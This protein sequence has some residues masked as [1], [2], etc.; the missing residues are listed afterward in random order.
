RRCRAPLPLAALG[1]AGLAA[2]GAHA[3]RAP[4][5][6]ALLEAAAETSGCAA[7]VAGAEGRQSGWQRGEECKCPKGTYLTGHDLQCTSMLD[8]SDIDRRYYFTA[9]EYEGRGCS[10][11]RLPRTEQQLLAALGEQ[12]RVSA[13]YE[14]LFRH[15]LEYLGALEGDG[16]S[17]FGADVDRDS[18]KPVAAGAFP[19]TEASQ[20]AYDPDGFCPLKSHSER[21][22][23]AEKVGGTI[24]KA[25]QLFNE[26]NVW[27][28][29]DGE[30]RP[31]NPATDDNLFRNGP[32]WLPFTPTW[33][34]V[35]AAGLMF[36]L[37]PTL[38]LTDGG[39]RTTW[40]NS[41]AWKTC[42]E[43]SPLAS[44]P[45]IFKYPQVQSRLHDPEQKRGYYTATAPQ[46]PD[47]FHPEGPLFIDGE[48]HQSFRRLLEL[49]G[50][51]RRYPVDASLVRAIPGLG[52]QAPSEADVA[53]AVGPLVMQGIWGSRPT[54][55]A[56]E[57][58]AIYA[59]FGKYA[60]FGKEIHRFALGPT[61]IASSV[62][63]ASASVAAWAKTTPF[64]D[65]LRKAAEA[66]GPASPFF[67]DEDRLLD[68]LILA[69]LFAGLVG[70]TDMVTKCV[71]YQ[72]RDAAH[73]GL[74]MEDP[75]KYLIELMR[76]DSAVT[77]VTELL[78][79]DDAMNLEGRNI[80]LKQGTPA[81]LVL[82]SANRDPT[83]WMRADDFDPAR[84]DL[85]DTLSWNGRV[86][87]V[88][89]RSL[90]RAPR[91]CPGFCLSLKVGAAVCAKMMGSFDELEREGKVLHH[92]SGAVKCNNF[93]EADEPPLWNPP[94][95]LKLPPLYEPDLSEGEVLVREDVECESPDLYIGSF[96][97]VHECARAV[98]AAGGK[99]FIYGKG[100]VK[101]GWCYMEYTSSPDCGQGFQDDWYDF[102]D[103]PEVPLERSLQC[104][105]DLVQ[106]SLR[107]S[108]LMAE[109]PAIGTLD[110]TQFQSQAMVIAKQVTTEGGSNWPFSSEKSCTYEH[111]LAAYGGQAQVDTYRGCCKPSKAGGCTPAEL[112]KHDT[113]KLVKGS[114]TW[115]ACSRPE[116]TLFE[117]ASFSGATP[118]GKSCFEVE[119]VSNVVSLR[120]KL[121][122][123]P[124]WIKMAITAFVE[125][126]KA[127]YAFHYSLIP[128]QEHNHFIASILG[129]EPDSSGL[130]PVTFDTYTTGMVVV[131]VH[132]TQRSFSG[133]KHPPSERIALPRSQEYLDR[134]V[135]YS[136]IGLPTEDID[137]NIA[138]L[139][140]GQTCGLDAFRQLDLVD[141]IGTGRNTWDRV[142]GT[143]PGYSSHCP[144]K[145]SKATCTK[146]EF[147]RG[148]FSNYTTQDGDPAYPAEMIDFA[149]LWH[150]ADGKWSDKAESFLAWQHYGSHRI[151]AVLAGSPEATGGAAFKLVTSDLSVLDVRPGFSRVGA[152]MFFNEAGEP[153]MIRTPDGQEVWRARAESATWQYWKFAFRSSLFL[154]VTLVDHL[155]ATHFTAGNSLA[156]AS[157]ESLAP[158]HPMR[159]LLTMFTFNTIKVNTNAFHQLLGPD[160]LLQRSTPFHDFR[161]V[162]LRAE[163][164]IRPLTQ[165]F[166]LFLNETVRSA[167]PVRVQE[168]PYVQDGQ[169]IFDA[170][171]DFVASWFALY[172]GQWCAGAAVADPALMLFF[173]RV[174]AWSMYQQHMDTDASFLGLHG[175][176]GNLQCAG[177]QK[178]LTMLFFQVTGGPPARGVRGRHRRGPGL[179]RLLLGAGRG[180]RE[181]A[182]GRAGLAHLGHDGNLLAEDQPGLQPPRAGDREGRRGGAGLPRVP[183]E[184]EGHRKDHRRSERGAGRPV[185]ADAPRLRGE[186]G[187]RLRAGI[188]GGQLR[189]AREA[190]RAR[191]INRA[192]RGASSPGVRR[193]RR[194]RACRR[195]V[196]SP[197]A[198]RAA[199][200]SSG[201]RRPGGDR[202]PA[203]R[204]AR[205]ERRISGRGR[206]VWP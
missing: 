93:N 158:T 164:A 141:D 85:K 72:Q 77:S 117:A 142:M 160:A 88:E 94:A 126:S 191:F 7:A 6:D 1:C 64:R 91:H 143:L 119:V 28:W 177:F 74:F 189:S 86:E 102:F 41:A 161:K 147:V 150:M 107:E 123:C 16:G 20:A 61:G 98:K 163:V 63:E 92:G 156:A 155:W 47:F 69:T 30:D 56:E 75:E 78:R 3:A 104:H 44:G 195:A 2:R 113:R 87:D 27:I 204:R 135:V 46:H 31:I 110:R 129:K 202:P 105:A 109:S 32:L 53:A 52:G 60:I 132:L 49:A 80:T 157:R 170:L 40:F 11:A 176:D 169:L 186:L 13:L 58:M 201:A 43:P 112:S 23:A 154:K 24:F 118:T 203:A 36:A 79:E 152:D 9:A 8:A 122:S 95:D 192:R 148:L 162:S 14:A 205:A 182:A 116:D 196:R 70:T 51:A 66:H 73:V 131:I 15:T 114:S 25:V 76:Y 128:E 199:A 194:P 99:Y 115:S 35:R 54:P 136:F 89:A 62:R 42:W 50:F 103:V 59:R 188:W 22:A 185:P 38:I 100:I 183:R 174:Q 71:V 125:L 34:D 121:N 111:R 190:Q 26:F 10:C 82:A 180:A 171:R 29:S 81:Q 198:S 127:S 181:A 144:F 149:G 83:H 168:T 5:A 138:S 90:E 133:A 206:S 65:L 124:D 101:G 178:W 166:G 4:P 184:A 55:E 18:S 130:D 45:M 120:Q 21:V 33:D 172:D 159:R 179:C 175:G 146:K 134:H 12:A 197:P 37:L 139:E 151:E 187:G 145:E 153:L 57:A 68:D 173:E 140:G 200:A 108:G 17:T 84:P 137:T 96:E 48:R 193:W 167:L 67:L 19:R 165:S 39:N 97:T 106:W